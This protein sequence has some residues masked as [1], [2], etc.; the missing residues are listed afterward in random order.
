MRCR[1]GIFV[2]PRSTNLQAPR[3]Q[4]RPPYNQRR[5]SPVLL[6]SPGFC[7]ARRC[8]HPCG[9][10][11]PTA[12]FIFIVSSSPTVL[13]RIFC[14]TG[15]NYLQLCVLRQS[16]GILCFVYRLSNRSCAAQSR[17]SLTTRYEESCQSNSPQEPDRPKNKGRPRRPFKLRHDRYRGAEGITARMRAIVCEVT[18]AAHWLSTVG[19]PNFRRS[20]E[21]LVM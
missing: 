14:N 1:R 17:E 9:R 7:S 20:S 5:I 15:N 10:F 3:V 8:A 21:R 11:K 2:F 6:T 13:S 18:W 16:R 12:R 19:S 4:Q